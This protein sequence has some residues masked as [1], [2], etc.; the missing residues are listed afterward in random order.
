MMKLK[1]LH[2][3]TFFYKTQ[4]YHN[5]SFMGNLLRQKMNKSVFD[6]H[7]TRLSFTSQVLTLLSYFLEVAD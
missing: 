3:Y 7:L 1:S 6:Q 2:K 4:K 5:N